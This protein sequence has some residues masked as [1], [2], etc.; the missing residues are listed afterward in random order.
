MRLSSV[1]ATRLVAIARRLFVVALVLSIPAH[2]TL[3]QAPTLYTRVQ[4]AA[5]HAGN[6]VFFHFYVMDPCNMDIRVRSITRDNH[7]ITVV[8]DQQYVG[9]NLP[10]G[11][12]CWSPPPDGV[13]RVSLGVLPAGSYVARVDHWHPAY[14]QS[15]AFTVFPGPIAVPVGDWAATLL[16]VLMLAA[17]AC[18]FEF[19]RGAAPARRNRR[20]NVGHSR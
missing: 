15:V 7:V 18:R 17:G 8:V 1:G 10:E 9:P 13:I 14:D 19:C 6:E 3:A 2:E 16:A 11:A 4:P 5:P 20:W 12:F